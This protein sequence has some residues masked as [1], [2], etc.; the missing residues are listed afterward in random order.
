M[1]RSDYE[2]SSVHNGICLKQHFEQMCLEQYFEKLDW[3]IHTFSN[4]CIF[5][6]TLCFCEVMGGQMSYCYKEC[7]IEDR[8]QD[9]NSSMWQDPLW[10][11][12]P[13]L[14]R[15]IVG[16]KCD[17]WYFFPCYNQTMSCWNL[18]FQQ[19]FLS[20]GIIRKRDLL[21]WSASRSWMI[22]MD[23]RRFS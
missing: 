5:I 13:L 12:F 15:E 3:K 20:V 4:P 17:I 22:P 18:V 14:G 6:C 7:F 1:S 8:M 11:S 16:W 19:L 10:F 21:G 2:F 23:S 9:E